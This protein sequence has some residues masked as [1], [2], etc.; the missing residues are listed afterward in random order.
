[1]TRINVVHVREL[2][3]QH[4]LAEIREITR[5]PSNLRTSLNRKSGPLRDSEIPSEYVLG[6]GHVKFFMDK[7]KW[8][9]GR[10]L[11]LL[12]ECDN[13]GFT[14]SNRDATIFKN[15]PSKFYGSYKATKAAKDLNRIRIQERIAT[16][17]E[18]YRYKGERYE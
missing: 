13:R 14:I 15:V 12:E 8:L 11:S 10:F 3:D 4:L 16:K 1:M 7:F 5:L 17:P 2:A 6:K 9:E 18:F